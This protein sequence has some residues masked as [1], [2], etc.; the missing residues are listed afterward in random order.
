MCSTMIPCIIIKLAID[1]GDID[2]KTSEH[3]NYAKLIEHIKSEMI[4]FFEETMSNS[5]KI[6]N[7]L[8]DVFERYWNEPYFTRCPF[9]IK[10]FYEN[11]WNEIDETQI[12]SFWNDM[13]ESENIEC[14]L[15]HLYENESKW[16]QVFKNKKLKSLIDDDDVINLYNKI[17]DIQIKIFNNP[18]EA[19]TDHISYF[20]YKEAYYI[21]FTYKNDYH[22]VIVNANF[23]V[24]ACHTNGII[25]STCK[26]YTIDTNFYY[27]CIN[28]IGCII[29]CYFE[30]V[31]N[32]QL[33]NF[34]F[35]FEDL[36][37]KF[38]V[39]KNL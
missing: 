26:K 12:K 38:I 17:N 31:L 18:R 16:I 32:T 2:T 3:K 33:T 5:H 30:L 39:I 10:Y 8:D 13:I 22:Y 28:A 19:L 24:K 11:K 23:K 37:P 1:V 9:I 34:D 20:D 27:D 35:K 29:Y 36:D 21:K 25:K 14:K 7:T 15:N 6:Y 4:N